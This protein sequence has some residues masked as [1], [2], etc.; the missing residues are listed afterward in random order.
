LGSWNPR[1]FSGFVVPLWRFLGSIQLSCGDCLK[2]CTCSVTA[3]KRSIV[4]GSSIL[5]GELEE[6]TV[7]LRGIWGALCLHTALTEISTHNGVNFGIH[8]CLCVPRL[9]LYLSSFTYAIYFV[10]DIS[11]YYIVAYLV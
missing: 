1:R 11:C 8:H 2:L 6:I 10:I 7:N 5:V 4:I 9:F 3:L